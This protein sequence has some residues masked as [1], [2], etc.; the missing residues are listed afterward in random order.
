MKTVPRPVV[1]MVAALILAAA[2]AAAAAAEPARVALVIG[3]GAYAAA[4]LKNPP[5]DARLIAGTLRRLGFEVLL[6][7]DLDQRGM[8]EAIFDFGDSLEEAGKDAV[9]LFYYAGHGVQVNGRN[10]LIPVGARIESERTVDLE[11]VNADSIIGT[12]AFAR[13]RLNFVILDACRNNPFQRSF[14]SAL[15]GLARMDAPRGTLVAYATSPGNVAADGEGDNSPYSEALARAMVEPGVQVE[16]MFR[17]VRVKVMAETGDRQTPWE[18]SSLTGA[19]YFNPAASVTARP[20]APAPAPAPRPAGQTQEVVF[21]QSVQDSN[22]PAMLRAYLDQYPDGVFAVLARAKLDRLQAPAPA[23]P[24]QDLALWQTVRDSRDPSDLKGFIAIFPE[25]P[26]AAEA[27]RRLAALTPPPAAPA[28]PKPAP[29]ERPQPTPEPAEETAALGPGATALSAVASEGDAER[30]LATHRPLIEERILEYYQRESFVYDYEEKPSGSTYQ[31]D[32]I[33]RFRSLKIAD[34]EPGQVDV[35]AEYDWAS[36]RI[37]T[38]RA[39][40][41]FRLDVDGTAVRVLKA[42]RGW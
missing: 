22:D 34:F 25:S 26:Y 42:W 24:P 7:V 23:K 6:R 21:W 33:K 13:S 14:R 15:R 41:T 36:G 16:E 9:G 1:C 3:N 31:A 32:R 4:P 10:Y 11:A 35:K 17:K 28:P 18:S 20:Q 8:K 12:M 39:Q 27:R 2:G 29:R 40:L 5:N 37:I 38:G 30:F 19:F